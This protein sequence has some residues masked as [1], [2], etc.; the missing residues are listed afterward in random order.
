MLRDVWGLSCL[1]TLKNVGKFRGGE[2]I[3]GGWNHLEVSSL[4]V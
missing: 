4:C 2:A 1:G 3:A